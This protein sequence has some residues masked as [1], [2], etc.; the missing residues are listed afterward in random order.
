MTV[1]RL[2][3]FIILHPFLH[4]S[5]AADLRLRKALQS[6][7]KLSSELFIPAENPGAGDACAEQCLDDLEIHRC[8]GAEGAGLAFRQPVAVLRGD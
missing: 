3:F 1:T 5:E 4:L 2:R 8:S 6:R 7:G